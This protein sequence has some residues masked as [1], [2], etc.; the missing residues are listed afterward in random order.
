MVGIRTN[1]W[2]KETISSR[3]D[4]ILLNKEFINFLSL[5]IFLVDIDYQ[6]KVT[7]KIVLK[8]NGS[9]FPKSSM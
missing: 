2:V 7:K 3:F 8:I 4:S 6:I 9:F 1:S 5:D